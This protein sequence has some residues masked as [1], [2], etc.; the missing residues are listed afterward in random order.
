MPL[1]IE[2]QSVLA[3]LNMLQGVIN[4][5]ASNSANC[6]TWCVT[7]VSAI[8]VLTIGKQKPG[9]ILVAWLP[10]AMFFLL[11]AY[12][13]S[14]ERDFRRI[15]EDFLDSMDEK[16]LFR[17]KPPSR[18]SYRLGA[19]LSCM[20]SFSAYPFYG[21]LALALILVACLAL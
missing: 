16:K 17:L 3:Y 19:I 4:R 15:Y 7:L 20:L 14:L 12:Y 1:D 2:K 5:M 8:L 11:D 9:A 18:A 10:L 6:K 13:L 21:V